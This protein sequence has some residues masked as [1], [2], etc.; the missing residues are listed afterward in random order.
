MVICDSDWFSRLK[1]WNWRPNELTI[2]D[3]QFA[4]I[5]VVIVV[6]FTGYVDFESF[7]RTLFPFV[8]DLGAEMR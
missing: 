3:G 4:H 7:D 5:H 1:G 8:G 2:L 6:F